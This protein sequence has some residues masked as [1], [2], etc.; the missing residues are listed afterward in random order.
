MHGPHIFGLGA[1]QAQAARIAD[2][3]DVMPGHLETRPFEG[4][5]HKMRPLDPVRGDDVYVLHSLHGDGL[6]VNDK[7]CRTWFFC[8]TLRDH[9]AA[10]VTLVAPYLAYAR[11]DRRTKPYDPINTRYV[12][13]LCE[14]V[15]IDRMLVLDVHNPAAYEN[16]FRH[17]AYNLGAAAVLLPAL[18]ARLK[19]DED[20]VVLSPDAGGMKRAEAFRAALAARWPRP[21]PLGL[22]EKHRSR[23]QVTGET[24]FADVRGRAAIIVDDMISRGTTVRHTAQAAQAAGARR[25]LAVATHGLFAEDAAV[26]LDKPALERIVVTDSVSPCPLSTTSLAERVDVVDT[27]ALWADAIRRLHQER[28]FSD[29][30]EA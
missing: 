23:D 16:A 5:E 19:H 14:A 21:V 13:M 27:T 10:R 1:Q 6:S 28:D 26:I 9:G 2:H 4:G 18:L 24:L 7:L 20:I 25:V 8:A 30:D 12:A 29:V 17:P 15:G 3:L 22:M 11:K